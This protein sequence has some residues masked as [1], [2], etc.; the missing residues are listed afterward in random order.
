MAE[1]GRDIN[2]EEILY[3][4]SRDHQYMMEWE[5]KYME[6]CIDFMQPYGDVL[7]VGFGMGYSANQIMKWNPKSYTVLEPD[8]MVYNRAVEWAKEYSNVTVLKQP[9]PDLT[10][11]GKYDCFFFDPYLEG[12]LTEVTINNCAVTF[13]VLKCIR[14]LAKDQS[15]Y[16]FYCSSQGNDIQ[17]WGRNLYSVLESLPGKVQFGIRIKPYDAEVPE[18]CN[19]CK[20]GWLF[21]PVISVVQ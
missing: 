12:D 19:Y 9:W 17:D 3:G 8:P 10:G 15:R 1:Y 4:S 6:D 14:E 13:F 16:S 11:L 18:H 20:T 2:Q 5:K 21:K 7:E